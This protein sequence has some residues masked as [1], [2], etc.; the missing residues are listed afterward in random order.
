MIR[1]ED[2]WVTP[3]DETDILPEELRRDALHRR[4]I[5]RIGGVVAAVLIVLAILFANGLV[6]AGKLWFYGSAY[7]SMFGERP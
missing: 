7:K 5:V 4:R 2:G 6:F 3:E 1:R